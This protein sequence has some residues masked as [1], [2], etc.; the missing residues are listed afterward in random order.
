MSDTRQIE[1]RCTLHVG[2]SQVTHLWTAGMRVPNV[3]TAFE[4]DEDKLAELQV[5]SA[6]GAIQL[7]EPQPPAPPLAPIE[8]AKPKRKKV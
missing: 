2:G 3:W 8:P 7:R 4:V 6:K 1:A 5:E